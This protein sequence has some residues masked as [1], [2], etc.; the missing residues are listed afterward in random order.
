MAWD[1]TAPLYAIRDLLAS[2]EGVQS[3]Q[4]G[5][6][7]SASTVVGAYVT[8]GPDGTGDQLAGAQRGEIAYFCALHYRVSGN[9]ASAEL[10]LAA[11]KDDLKHK[12]LIQR[13]AQTGLFQTS[14]TQVQRARLDLTLASSPEYQP[15]AGQELR[16]W[17]FW[18]YCTQTESFSTGG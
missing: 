10:A 7:A 8:L 3:A 1:S 18:I 14:V 12:W 15:L 5:A 16:V 11:A 6:P 17:P 13:P 9:A 2:L 4:I